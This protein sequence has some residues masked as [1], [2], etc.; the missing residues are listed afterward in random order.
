[1]SVSRLIELC[2]HLCICLFTVGGDVYFDQPKFVKEIKTR[3]AKENNSYVRA[4]SI[5]QE[6]VFVLTNNSP[7][8]EVYDVVDL[9]LKRCF[10]VNRLRNPLDMKACVAKK[11][12]YIFDCVCVGQPGKMFKIDREG[13]IQGEFPMEDSGARLSVASSGN[14][15][16]SLT[17]NG[18]I[19]EYNM[20]NGTKV[21]EI[22]VSG[23]R[24]AIL[25]DNRRFII[26]Q[27]KS[28]QSELHRAML[29]RDGVT[30]VEVET[31]NAGIIKVIG[32]DRGLSDNA[33]N[34]P[35]YLAVDG[36][37]CILIADRENQRVTLFS[38][39]LEFKKILI[40]QKDHLRRPYNMLI[41]VPRG[42]LF[43]TDFTREGS[44]IVDGRLLV[45]RIRDFADNLA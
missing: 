16:V 37:G 42:R 27:G 40:S 6:E 19:L 28:D 23:L 35:C 22:K 13:H 39:T 20:S 31:N 21:H 32:G 1:M 34:V 17:S 15:I 30:K 18:K 44:D 26:C 3:I 38:S 24:H 12:L 4:V 8:I 36:N 41:D 10:T 14:V 25:L 7:E 33:M 11:C 43:V 29:I 45:F 2:L 5:L 9:Y